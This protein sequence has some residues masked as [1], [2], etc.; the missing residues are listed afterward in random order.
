MSLTVV[1][2]DGEQ[3]IVYEGESMTITAHHTPISIKVVN[4]QDFLIS[5]D[6]LHEIWKRGHEIYGD[7][8]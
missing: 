5:V 1:E 6:E 8:K 7:K 3:H 4:P 2:F